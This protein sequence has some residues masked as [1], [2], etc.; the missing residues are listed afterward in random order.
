MDTLKEKF[1]AKAQPMAVEVKALIKEF[2]DRKLGEYTIAQVY[3]GMKSIT[4]LVTETSKLDPDEG[5]RFR[6]YTIPELREK[7]PKAP[8][9]GTE[10][11][12]EGIFYLMLVG[13]LPTA[14]DVTNVANN[15]ARRSIV[16]KHVFDT[17]DS[18]P[19]S[20]HPMT[21]FSIGIMAMQ[22]ESVFAAAYKKGINKKDYWDY[23]YEDSMNL[24]ARL[25]RVA[26]YIYRKK[27]KNDVHIEP[28]PKLDWAANI[29]HMMGYEDF[30][31]QR[32]MRM[33]MTIHADHEGG[34]VSAHTTHLVGSALSD[35][36]LSFAAS[37]NGLAGPLHGL[38]NQE[39]IAWIM[40]MREQL[41]GGLPTE[42]QIADFIKKTLEEGKVVPGYG[43]AVLRKTD[44]RFTAQQD[45]Y[46]RYIAVD[47]KKDD[48]CEIVQTI[49]K[50]APPILSSTG[51]IKNP[52]PNV[53]AHSGALLMHFGIRE[54][55]F[56]TV[57][58]GVSRSL[59]VLASLIWDRALGHPIERPGSITTEGIKKKIAAMVTK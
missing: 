49:Y 26:A 47:G 34:N 43:H 42:Q 51:K 13:D 21:M 6:G 28:D 32:L 50:V 53:D 59:G 46:H 45:F 10:P 41:G 30:N 14:E 16:P 3:Q 20:T 48:L 39:V 24:I 5:I 23:M 35:P 58:F 15:W 4:G 2:G 52:W 29:A 33:Y 27:Y 37:M 9:G 18:L 38:A 19:L 56:Y 7:L 31:V 17:I 22:T 8:N 57:L 25:P 40:H 44:P 11:L 12:P 1:Y 55:D 54:F 36:Y